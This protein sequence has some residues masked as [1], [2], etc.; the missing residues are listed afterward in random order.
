MYGAADQFALTEW[1]IVNRAHHQSIAN[2]KIRSPVIESRI[3]GHI[4]FTLAGAE[5]HRSRE[6]VPQPE[7]EPV[8]VSFVQIHLQ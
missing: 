6:S 8:A 3:P 1:Q 4:R 2:V 7:I 5:I